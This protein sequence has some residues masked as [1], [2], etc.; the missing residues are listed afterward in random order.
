MRDRQ[1]NPWQGVLSADVTDN[2]RRFSA[3]WSMQEDDHCFRVFDATG[4][5][6]CAVRHDRLFK[7]REHYAFKYS[8]ASSV[9]GFKKQAPDLKEAIAAA[10]FF[11]LT[12]NPA[13]AM[14]T[15]ADEARHPNPAMERVM[16]KLGGGADGAKK[17]D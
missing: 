14:G 17:T 15:G 9:E 8:V 4:F 7:L 6:I 12:F 1:G 5:F 2:L 16:K 13:T 3:P 10:A 11:E